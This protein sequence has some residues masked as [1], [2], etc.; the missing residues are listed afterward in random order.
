MYERRKTY[1]LN[2]FYIRKMSK[3][4]DTKKEN[5]MKKQILFIISLLLVLPLGACGVFQ[6]NSNNGAPVASGTIAANDVKISSEIGGKIVTVAV[7]E[8]D[9]VSAGEELFQVDDEIAQSQY[10]QAKAAVDA[11]NATV[12]AAEAQLSN[13]Q[14]QYELVLQ[15]A[16][17]QDVQARD[18]AW[19]A[20]Q[21][22]EIK[23]PVWYYEKNERIDA[24]K[25][26]VE[27]AG[28]DLDTQLANLEK[29]LKDASND[30]FIETEKELAQTQAAFHIAGMTLE[31]AKAANDN[32]LVDV[33][34]K[35]YD[36]IL[37]DL[38]AI[39]R[40][41]D[42]ML[43]TSAADD[44]LQARAKVTVARSRLDN[45]QDQLIL[46]QQGD[47]SLQV[48]AARAGVE[49]AKT[50]VTQAQANLTQAQAALK[51]LEIQIEKTSVRAPVSGTIISLN[52]SEGELLTP[53]SVA[54][55]IGQ[56]D[57]V[58]I[59]VFVPED[60]YGEIDLGQAV[61]VTADSFPGVNYE[62]VVSHIADQAEFTP[63]NVQTADGRKTTVYTI[64]ILVPNENR[65]NHS[66]RV[67]R[68]M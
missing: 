64:K 25:T 22:N 52:L 21:D 31:Q 36:S 55:T 12:S 8:G 43:T 57:E 45:A 30:D 68:W 65:I 13:A 26:E 16:R 3:L 4:N 15:N 24:L 11:A 54:L 50:A 23:V 10:N 41:Y 44:V 51:T 38:D 2:D 35:S 28:A 17:M 14:L 6:S 34:Q 48:E 63:R 18:S 7:K 60:K 27:N 19:L 56:L 39:Q 5:L 62:G 40:N 32:E 47:E 20:S 33:A 29:E 59:T 58:E 37:A 46:L 67:C 53:G 49:Q 42:R 61:T 66:S 1:L 9:V